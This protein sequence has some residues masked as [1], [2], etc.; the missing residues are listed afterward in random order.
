MQFLSDIGGYI[1][2]PPL[3]HVER[4]DADGVLVLAGEEVLDH[5]LPVG[6]LVVGLDPC[7]AGF[8]E[9]VGYQIDRV[10]SVSFGTIEAP[11]NR[12][13]TFVPFHRSVSGEKGARRMQAVID[14]VMA[15]YRMM[16][17]L[18]HDE[19]QEARERVGRFLQGKGTDEH[20]LAVEGHKYLRGRP[21]KQRRVVGQFKTALSNS[22]GR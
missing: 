10:W 18:T 15:T 1:F 22:S 12:E 19:E 17:Q 16:V 11:P 5:G 8:P 14:R 21:A 20:M 2:Q 7:S 4:D 6:G 9:V 13:G 3:G